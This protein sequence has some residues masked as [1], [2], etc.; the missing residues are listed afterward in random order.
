MT[1][2]SVSFVFLFFFFCT[3]DCFGEYEFTN[4]LSKIYEFRGFI[5]LCS[6]C[7]VLTSV[8]LILVTMLIIRV[9]LY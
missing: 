1:D 3:A 6:L 8:N 9:H 4:F 7:V 2:F 5:F